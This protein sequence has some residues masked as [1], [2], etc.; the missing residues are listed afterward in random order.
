MILC[1]KRMYKDILNIK[2]NK[3]GDFLKILFISFHVAFNA[4]STTKTT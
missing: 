4:K 2:N 3:L 1:L